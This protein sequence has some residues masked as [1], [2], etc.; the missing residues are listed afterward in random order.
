[1]FVNIQFF[2]WFFF[3]LP[4]FLELPK[5][6]NNR[7]GNF[8]ILLKSKKKFFFLILFVSFFLFTYVNVNR[9]ID[10][11][12]FTR[13]QIFRLLSVMFPFIKKKKRR[14]KRQLKLTFLFFELKNEEKA[15][16]NNKSWYFY[17]FLCQFW[18]SQLWRQ[19]TAFFLVFIFLFLHLVK[20]FVVNLCRVIKVLFFK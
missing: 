11:V 4:L 14:E 1:M 2:K 19:T 16:E 20:I 8:R 18:S 17:K 15:F 12:T 7:Q 13:Y 6:G 5:L 9:L 10:G 3:C